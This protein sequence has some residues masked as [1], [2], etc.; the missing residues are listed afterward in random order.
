MQLAFLGARV[1]S[2]PVLLNHGV[3]DA[4]MLVRSATVSA[5][6]RLVFF[7]LLGSYLIMCPL[8]IYWFSKMLKGAIT[9]LRG[10]DPEKDESLKQ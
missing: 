2:I 5:S 8:N 3:H 4:L 9:L 6:D 7:W 10:E 1:L